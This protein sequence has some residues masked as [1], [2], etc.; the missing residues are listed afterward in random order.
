MRFGGFIPAQ[1]EEKKLMAQTNKTITL[2]RRRHASDLYKLP[3]SSALSRLR[4]AAE[5]VALPNHPPEAFTHR[6]RFGSG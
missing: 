6:L 2:R 4:W 5:E 1:E 3:R